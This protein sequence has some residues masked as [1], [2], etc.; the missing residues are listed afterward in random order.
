MDCEPAAGTRRSGIQKMKLAVAPEGS[1]VGVGRV[2]RP[3][4]ASPRATSTPRSCRGAP[5]FRCRAVRP[6][7]Q[8]GDKRLQAGTLGRPRLQPVQPA[9]EAADVRF[10]NCSLNWL[11]SS[12]RR[13]SR[14]EV[15]VPAMT[16]F[17][18]IR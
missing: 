17:E 4:P 2:N 6:L 15:I 11:I 5:A 8:S 10:S 3:S 14:P 7:A 18:R 1:M 16:I 12:L 13:F 9:K